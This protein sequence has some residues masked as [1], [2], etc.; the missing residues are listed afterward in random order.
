[1]RNY[2]VNFIVDSVLS[3]D[4][5][6]AT[7]Q[8]YFDMLT[9]N[10]ATIVD[11]GEMGLRQLAYPIKGRTTGVYFCTE[12]QVPSGA[13]I[14]QLE[15]ALRRDERIMRFLSVKLDKFGVKYNDDKRNGLIGKK[16]DKVKSEIKKEVAAEKKATPAKK[17]DAP[18]KAAPAPVAKAEEEE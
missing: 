5:I 14:A 13:I 18:A 8:T 6:N 1:M 2:E 15:L 9:S 10:E 11:K 16:K 12:F 4:E 17:A 3:G 7:A